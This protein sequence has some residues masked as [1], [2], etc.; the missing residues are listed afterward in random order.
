MTSG[1]PG[2]SHEPQLDDTLKMSG[3]NVPRSFEEKFSVSLEHTFLLLSAHLPVTSG[4][5]DDYE[6]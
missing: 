1:T 5:D 4:L 6:N 2:L 3:L